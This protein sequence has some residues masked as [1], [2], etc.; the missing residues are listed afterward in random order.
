MYCYTVVLHIAVSQ[1]DKQ[2]MYWFF[3]L[4]SWL[5]LISPFPWLWTADLFDKVLLYLVASD[6]IEFSACC[7]FLIHTLYLHVVQLVPAG[8]E[9]SF[10]RL[11]MHK[12]QWNIRKLN[13][14]PDDP[15]RNNYSGA[16][17]LN[18]IM[19]AMLYICFIHLYVYLNVELA[20]QMEMRRRGFFGK[21]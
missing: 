6:V 11:A 12:L 16:E 18:P 8:Y 14:P 20:S 2:Q 17:I 10:I 15:F 4:P 9:F 7:P 21:K 19:S 1:W 5:A 13:F 3:R